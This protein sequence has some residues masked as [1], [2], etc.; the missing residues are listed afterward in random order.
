MIHQ[1]VSTYGVGL[2]ITSILIN[3]LGTF[4]LQLTFVLLVLPCLMLGYLGQAAYLM[5]N[6]DGAEQAFFSSIPSKLQ[7]FFPSNLS[8]VWTFCEFFR[9]HTCSLILGYVIYSFN[10]PLHFGT[11]YLHKFQMEV[12]SGEI[13]P[14]L[15]LQMLFSGLCSS[16][17]T[18]LH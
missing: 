12:N 17:L 4:S 2:R 8:S 15:C 6:P 1:S 9:S 7:W 16:L 11:L 18:L 13:I 5:E 3:L 14:C 10:I